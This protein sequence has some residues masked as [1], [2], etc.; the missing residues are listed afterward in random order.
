MKRLNAILKKMNIFFKRNIFLKFTKY[1][2]FISVILILL[3]FI[4]NWIFPFRVN[5]E[6][7]TL[8]TGKND[9]VLKAFLTSDDKW[10]MRT[11]LEE[12]TPAMQKA[13]IYKEDKYFYYHFG[14]NP[15][16]MVRAAFN[17]I[18]SGK[19]TSGASTIT[20]QVARLLEPKNRT[21][22]NKMVE[23]FRSFQLEAKYSKA[24]ILQLYLNLVPY[25]GNI[26]GVKAASILYLQKT[27]GVLSIAELTALSI[28]PNRPT[29]L[30]PGVNNDVIMQER[31][32]WLKRF[33]DAHLFPEEE[34]QS[35]LSEPFTAFRTEGPDHAPHFCTRMKMQYPDIPNIKT[36]IDL[37][38]QVQAEKL[39]SDHVRNLWGLDIHN[40][41]AIVID[42]ETHSVVAYV[43]SAD[44]Y[45]QYDAGQVD[46]VRAVRS[47]G[48]TLKPLLYALAFDKGYATPQT[49]ISDV[50]VNYNGYSPENY[51]E[52][53]HGNVSV[54]SA[55]A[56]SYNIPA[57]KMLDQIGVSDL[58]NALIKT[59]FSTVE[60]QK[61][62]LGLSVVLGGCGV[63]LE[64]LT[65]LYAVFAS[66]GIY[67]KLCWLQDEEKN[68]SV[69]VIS[70][71]SSF[72]ITEI[73]SQLVR[74]D[75]PSSYLYAKDAPV[76]AWKTG[77]SYGRKDAWSIGYNDHYTIGV[78]VGNFSGRGVPELS[79]ANVAT[80]LL[81]NLFN[82]IDNAQD[83]IWNSMP[84][85][86]AFRFVCSESGKIPQQ[87]C[88]HV[89][90]DYFIP[91]VSVNQQCDHLITVKVSADEKLSYC[92]SCAPQTGFKEKVYENY[93]PEILDWMQK[94]HL[95]FEAIPPH[96]PACERIFISGAPQITSPVN[97]LE[98]YV[99]SADHEK[100]M[101]ACNA[102]NDVKNIYWYVGGKLYA[103]SE[104]SK[105]VFIEAMPGITDITCSDDKGRNS[106]IRV[107]IRYW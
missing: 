25:G 33:R 20:M 72:M 81:F 107:K 100:V 19:R 37:G 45:A 68:D 79:G 9:E 65:N 76:I 74:P 22:G 98:Y 30:R 50:P 49:L 10:R 12:I 88:D 92:M 64:E 55:L 1:S 2:F 82:A 59:D 38:K 27:P 21:Y 80:P 104:A 56:N 62:D 86:V 85:S 60:K 57:V 42:N 75:Y 63:A 96:D 101:L 14:I 69:S 97:G 46:G 8:V 16:A 66:H 48:S 51:D 78:W 15:F 106:V 39:I 71:A 5:V 31:N 54:E 70:D 32:K 102:A 95:P 18:V 67:R 61:K 89:V 58:V 73:L 83:K 28:I 84:S 17:N 6:Y 105:P 94:Q 87:F 103:R 29:S 26:E 52:Q 90:M 7:S 40:A 13:I 36:T 35:A 24:E 41:A 43:G 77:T 3:F 53:Y 44:F 93:S 11:E 47:P 4:L 91:G 34:I 23:I 99:D